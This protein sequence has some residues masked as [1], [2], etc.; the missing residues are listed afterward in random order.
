MCYIYLLENEYEKFLKNKNTEAHFPL[1]VRA[2][3][4]HIACSLWS[5]VLLT[6][7]EMGVKKEKV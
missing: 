5:I 6:H 4:F 7:E 2:V 3:T 1:A